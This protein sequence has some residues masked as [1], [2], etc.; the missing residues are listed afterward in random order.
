[1]EASRSVANDGELFAGMYAGLLRFAAA[2][3]PVGIDPEDLVQEALARA[4]AIRPLSELDEPATY[5]RTAMVHIASN[6]Q[7]GRRRSNVRL[8][9]VDIKSDTVDGYPS[10]L[11][12]L[13][14]VAPRARAILYLTVIEGEQYRTAAALVGCSEAAARAIASRALRDLQHQLADELDSKEPT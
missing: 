5:L 13:L 2:V 12:D 11:A 9:R 1:V 3:R 14:R 8:A 4:L 7:R 10:D 6:L